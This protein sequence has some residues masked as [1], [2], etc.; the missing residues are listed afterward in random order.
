MPAVDMVKP[1]LW[2]DVTVEAFKTP[3]IKIFKFVYEYKNFKDI[4]NIII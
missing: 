2:H 1:L 3:S 4:Y